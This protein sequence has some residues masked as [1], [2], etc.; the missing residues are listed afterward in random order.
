LHEGD[1]V[2]AV[3]VKI[4]DGVGGLDPVVNVEILGKTQPAPWS[5][6]LFDG[7]AQVIVQFTKNAGEI[8]LTVSANGLNTA[9]A[10]ILTNRVTVPDLPAQTSTLSVL[11]AP[12]GAII[13]SLGLRN[14]DKVRLAP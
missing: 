8:E 4:N 12:T 13:A 6:S 2:I 11:N 1:N 7:L 14:G 5:R 10:T 3:G 9:T